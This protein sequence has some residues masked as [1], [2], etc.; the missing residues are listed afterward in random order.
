V[1]RYKRTGAARCFA[2]AWRA[3]RART[4]AISTRPP[5][6]Q[7]IHA[8][9]KEPKML[10]SGGWEQPANT[11][12]TVAD[13]PASGRTEVNRDR[14]RF[15]NSALM[16]C[17]PHTFAE[18]GADPI[19]STP[20]ALDTIGISSRLSHRAENRIYWTK[21]SINTFASDYRVAAAHIERELACA[22]RED[23]SSKTSGRSI[24]SSNRLGSVLL[25]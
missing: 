24:R 1:L 20:R 11:R 12:I 21:V 9:K 6:E 15:V 14:S 19:S 18:I 2:I 8:G 5:M 7:K 22:G 3:I 17:P 16:P 10:Y 4:P 25:P 23:A 13:N